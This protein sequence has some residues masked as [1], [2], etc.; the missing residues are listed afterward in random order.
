MHR[1]GEKSAEGPSKRKIPK[2]KEPEGTKSKAVLVLWSDACSPQVWVFGPRMLLVIG[3]EESA[4]T[5]SVVK[6][7]WL[8]Q[9]DPRNTNR[10]KYMAYKRSQ[11]PVLVS[12]QPTPKRQWA[13]TQGQNQQRHNQVTQQ[14]FIMLNLSTSKASMILLTSTS[15]RFGWV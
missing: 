8:N 11:G 15:S 1:K 5:R 3:V 2:V 10:L 4:T 7:K 9:A 6:A 12:F 14:C 13:T